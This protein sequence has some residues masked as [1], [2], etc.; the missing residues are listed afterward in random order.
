MLPASPVDACARPLTRCHASN[1]SAR[2]SVSLEHE[3]APLDITAAEADVTLAAIDSTQS[4]SDAAAALEATAKQERDAAIQELRR[5][6][7]ELRYEV[8]LLNELVT[9][10]VS[11]PVLSQSHRWFR[12][13][14]LFR[15]AEK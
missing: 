5:R 2:I 1:C 8:T 9:P 6:L 15:R 3:N 12:R 10:P 4:L 14:R 11:S 13:E 7:S